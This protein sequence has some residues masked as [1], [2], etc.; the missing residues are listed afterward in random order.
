[1]AFQREWWVLVSLVGSMS[2]QTCAL[3]SR[4]ASYVAYH[5][6]LVSVTHAASDPFELLRE[7]IRGF[8]RLPVGWDSYDAE[9][10]SSRAVEAALALVAELEC[11]TIL[12]EWVVPTSDASI[13]LQFHHRGTGFKWEFDADGD[14]AVMVK[15]LFDQPEFF[16]LQPEDVSDFLAE[17][18]HA[19]V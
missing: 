16:D 2:K 5:P 11:R 6:T 13:L 12:P 17:R 4:Q 18:V 9:P 7:R 8:A 19:R 10:P 15:G 3:T 1:L 14:I